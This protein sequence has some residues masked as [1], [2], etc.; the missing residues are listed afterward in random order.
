MRVLYISKFLAFFGELM[1]IKLDP[2]RKP[3][4]VAALLAALVIASALLAS[5][6]FGE[7]MMPLA[8]AS[9]ASLYL[10]EQKK[11]LLSIISSLAVIAIDVLVGGAFTYIGIEIVSLSILI[12]V[13][14]R[15]GV[16]KAEASFWTSLVASLF[17]L[18]AMVLAA[19]AD[20]GEISTDIFFDYYI[21]LASTLRETFVEIMTSAVNSSQAIAISA[22]DI[23]Y[24]FDSFVNSLPSVV[25]V[26]AFV[27]SG[28][29][30]KITSFF[31]FRFSDKDGVKWVM[32]WR[33]KV[34]P[35]VSVAFWILAVINIFSAGGDS[36][37][38]IVVANLF[39]IFVA[40][41]AYLGFKVV[42]FLLTG[43]FRSRALA[44]LVLI[45]TLALLNSLAIELLAYFGAANLFIGFRRTPSG[46]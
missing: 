26:G 16:S 28:I 43:I 11:K 18:V 33:F 15:L 32:S 40:V 27:L 36:L 31:L 30:L 24:V 42:L 35:I 7:V 22:E 10:L 14:V 34:P 4:S 5:L 39:N 37:F 1:K 19:W 12:A 45:G 25:A 20:M 23:A 29:T 41:F 13:L 21:D 9:L 38:A 17:V 44:I 3:L 6:V 2:V 46:D 8:V